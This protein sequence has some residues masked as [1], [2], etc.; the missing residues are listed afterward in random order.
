VVKSE[1]DIKVM[2]QELGCHKMMTM[3]ATSDELVF[4]SGVLVLQSG[5]LKP[6]WT[7]S[8]HESLGSLVTQ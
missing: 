3:F 2:D 5:L 7:T 1:D 8:F 6:K 4:E